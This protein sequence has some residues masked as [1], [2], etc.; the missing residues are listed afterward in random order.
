MLCQLTVQN[1][2]IVKFLEL[3][4]DAGMTT[5]TGETG[6]GKSIAIDALGLCL[7][8]R[9][10]AS[11][12]RPGAAKAEVS[13][14][15]DL[16]QIP[17]AQAWLKANELDGEGECLLR[18][19]V[20]QDGRSRGYI[21]GTPVP[22]AQLK[23]LGEL[24]VSVHGQHAHHA[25]AKSEHQLELLDNYANHQGL[26][27]KVAISYRHWRQCANQLEALTQSQSER[28]ARQQL[29]AYQVAELDEF[30]PSDNEYPE[31]VQEHK[32]LANGSQLLQAAQSLV[33]LL[34]EDPELNLDSLLNQGVSQSSELSELDPR[35]ASVTEMLNTALIQVQESRGELDAYLQDLELDPERLAQLETRLSQYHEL[36]RK[37]QVHPEAVAQTHQTLAEELAGLNGED[38]A[39]DELA[40]ALEQA[41]SDYQTKAR[42]LSESRSRFAAQLAKKVTKKMA[43][44]NM[45]KGQFEIELTPEQGRSPLGTDAIQFLVTTNPGQP[46]APMTKVASG[47]ELSRIGLALQVLCSS[48]NA[49]P[50]L[51]F[52]EVD[53]GISG[54]TASVVGNLLRTLGKT[55]QVFCV[56]HLPQVAGQGHQQLKVAKQTR[57]GETHT[58]MMPLDRPARL[59]ELARLLAGDTIT[60]VAL[61]NAEQLLLSNE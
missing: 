11:M 31:L 55:S 39:L 23:Q 37:H 43:E 53:T 22:L 61:A 28:Q 13:A 10:E 45:P 21:N 59:S 2:A 7:G 5:I 1:F 26:L 60:D 3:D 35:L 29:L 18:R 36:G 58:S 9:A 24:L 40:Q 32:T 38:Q 17:A 16:S 48:K 30:A 14:Q 41:Q 47:G 51:I 46:L 6:A 56:T 52:D 54:A 42:K 15:F 25:L 20:N 33:Q 57:K 50:T 27:D 12:V 19:L 34:G 8:R 4:F 49:T 44:L